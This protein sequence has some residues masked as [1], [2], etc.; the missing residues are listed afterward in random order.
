[1]QLADSVPKRNATEVDAEYGGYD[2]PVFC[3]A[4]QGISQAFG[5]SAGKVLL[6]SDRESYVVFASAARSPRAVSVVLENDCLPLF[7]IPEVGCV[8]G[9]GG[10]TTLL[11]ARFFA[12]VMRIPCTLFPTV[13]TLAGALEQNARITVGGDTVPAEL[14]PERT[15]CDTDLLKPTLGRAY[16]RLLLA[17]LAALE[18]RALRYFGLDAVRKDFVP[19][20]PPPSVSSAKKIVRANAQ[21]GDLQG[22]GAALA[23]LLDGDGERVPEWRAYLQLSAL[24]AAFF[25]KGKPRRYY[26][27]D[28]KARADEAET[29]VSCCIPTAEEYAQR[30]ILLERMR[31]EMTAESLSLTRRREEFLSAVRSLS[32]DP[33][34]DGG[35]DL[36]RLKFLPE[37]FQGGLCAVIRDFGLMEW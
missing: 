29:A 2:E 3:T 10:K 37:H 13:A 6:V 14:R 4:E 35:G 28:Y 24:Y 33:V 23:A 21:I 5:G 9:A 16:S 8:L 25:T 27:P 30:A 20:L 22:E 11:A 34:A 31:A 12:K 7:A 26:T 19:E 32:A 36:K 17:R 15:V 18:G 1:M